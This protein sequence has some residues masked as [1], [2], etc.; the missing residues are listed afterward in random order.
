MLGNRP[1][2]WCRR[3]DLLS[4]DPPAVR[5]LVVCVQEGGHRMGKEQ[6]FEDESPDTLATR[7]KK[8]PMVFMWVVRLIADIV[9]ALGKMP[10]LPIAADLYTMWHRRRYCQTDHFG[11]PLHETANKA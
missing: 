11:R 3:G 8:L 10:S 6:G 5:Q 4:P 9:M 1:T 7:Q 2:S